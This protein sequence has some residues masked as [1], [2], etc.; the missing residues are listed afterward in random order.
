MVEERKQIIINKKLK[1]ILLV[2]SVA[3]AVL[4]VVSVSISLYLT[5]YRS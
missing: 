2:I 3:S 1:N 4:S 5:N